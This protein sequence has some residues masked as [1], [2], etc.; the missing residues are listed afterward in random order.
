[1]RTHTNDRPERSVLATLRQLTPQRPATFFEALRIAELQANRLLELWD[2]D[3]GPVPTDVVSELP[4]IRVWRESGLPVSGSSHW[5]G[6]RHPSFGDLRHRA[7]RRPA[8]P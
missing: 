4:S 6:H 2:V 1:M 5:S 8:G 7:Q 3:D